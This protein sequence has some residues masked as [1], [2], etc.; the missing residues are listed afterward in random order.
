MSTPAPPASGVTPADVAVLLRA[1]TKDNE[2]R[3]VGLFTEATRPS[4]NQVEQAIALAERTIRARVGEPGDSCADAYGAAVIHETAC[5]IEKSYWPEQ[6]HSER[7]PYDQLRIE[8]EAT[9]RGLQACISEYGG[10]E[11]RQ[12]VYDVRTP[13]A[14]VEPG[15]A[16]WPEHVLGNWNPPEPVP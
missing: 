1:R 13:P 14:G 4:L 15:D 7:S 12:G 9:V 5:Q 11:G 8:A 16:W 6:V 3:E 2:G 10:T